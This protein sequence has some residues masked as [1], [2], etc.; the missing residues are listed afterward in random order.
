MHSTAFKQKAQL[1]KHLNNNNPIGIFD[2]GIGGLTVANAVSG[3]LPKE[4]F[5]YFG[6]TIHFPYGDR[7]EEALL[8][9]SDS[10]SDFLI[11]K[12][13][14]AIVIACN[15]ASSVATQM[16]EEK[17]GASIPIINVIDPV[18]DEVA[19]SGLKSIGV[20]GTKQTIDSKIYQERLREKAP[21]LEVHA[22]ATRSLATIIEE[23]LHESTTL[24]QAIIENYCKTEPFNSIDGL[25]LGCTHYPLIAREFEHY[26]RNRVRVFNHPEIV[27]YHLHKV[28][29]EQGLL[30]DQ[31][32]GHS[33][34]YFSDISLYFEETV[35]LLFGESV[36]FEQVNLWD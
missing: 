3:L 2:S 29:Q 13:C 1:N 20:I 25:I 31:S 5:V 32:E 9:Y 15:T 23:G 30:A 18:V 14:K 33:K 22:K 7:S 11:E 8:S 35:R 17:Y 12:N 19:T 6:D 4:S 10:I 34:F 27:V 36:S 21:H 16:L 24:I 26:F 28:L